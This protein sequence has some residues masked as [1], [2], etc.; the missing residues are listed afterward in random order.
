MVEPAPPEERQIVHR[1]TYADRPRA[2]YEAIADLL[3]LDQNFLVLR[4]VRTG[5]D[6]VVD[7]L[8]EPA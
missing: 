6:V 7:R 4:H 3:D 1:R 2:T 5:E 8:V